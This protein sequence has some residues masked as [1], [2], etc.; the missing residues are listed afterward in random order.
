MGYLLWMDKIRRYF[1]T[2]G[3]HSLFGIYRGAIIL[4]FL[5]WCR[6]SSIHSMFDPQLY[7]RGERTVETSCIV[8]EVQGE[9]PGTSFR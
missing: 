4:G 9:P 3:N 7:F 6:I 5:R 1:E 2:M 8:F